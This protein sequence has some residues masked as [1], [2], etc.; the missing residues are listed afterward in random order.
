MGAFRPSILSVHGPLASYILPNFT[1]INK[2]SEVE[3]KTET[4]NLIFISETFDFTTEKYLCC[5]YVNFLIYI[6]KFITLLYFSYSDYYN[7][8]E[9]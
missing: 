2:T 8:I 4:D 7:Y 5:A 9:K 6:T 3:L 1:V